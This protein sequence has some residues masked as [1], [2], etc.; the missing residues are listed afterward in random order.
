MSWLQDIVASIFGLY[1][2]DEYDE[3]KSKYNN[4]IKSIDDL[5]K[6]NSDLL[7]ST[8][9]LS[10]QVIELQAQIDKLKEEMESSSDCS[11][12]KKQLEEAIANNESLTNEVSNLK[13]TIATKEAIISDYSSQIETLEH[14][15]DSMQTSV[16]QYKSQI[17]SLKAQFEEDKQDYQEQIEKVQNEKAQLWN[18]LNDEKLKNDQLEA[19]VKELEEKL[20]EYESQEKPEEEKCSITVIPQDGVTF[21]ANGE[22]I[23]GTTW[24]PKGSSVTLACYKDGE[25]ADHF[26]LEES[27]D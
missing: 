2:D 1:T 4:A 19:K 14:K 11:A 7:D 20:K 3:L 27:D 13:N 25:L 5:N 10:K 21:T 12:L 18:E 24:Y 15:V 23:V 6:T 16:D 9:S 26:L 22:E 17:D 8:K